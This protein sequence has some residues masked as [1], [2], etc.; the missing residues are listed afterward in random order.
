L[1][2]ASTTKLLRTE[3]FLLTIFKN[4][5][6]NGEPFV[7]PKCLERKIVLLSETVGKQ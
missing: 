7:G 5:N 2:G 6:D 4:N 3:T 1:N